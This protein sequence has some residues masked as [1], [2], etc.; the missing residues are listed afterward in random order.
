MS[1]NSNIRQK[2]GQLIM[3]D[4]RYW[5][6]DSNNQR[7]PFTKTNDIVNKIFKDYNLGGF[8]LFRENI[9]NNEQVISL[10][11]DL[12]AN[13]NT[14]IFFATDQEGG[15]VNRL[16]QGISGCGNMALAATDNPHNAYTMAKIIGDELYSLGININ[17]APAVD[18]NSNKNN[19]IIGVRSYSDNPDIVI[20]YAKNAI[21]GYHDAKI[22]DCIKH[23]PGHGDTA[24]DSHL[25]NVN[26][27][28]T[29]KELQTTEL[30][31]FSKLA[32]DCSMIM[33]AHISVPALDDTQYQSVST[34]ENIYVPATLSYKIITK[35]LKQQMKFDGLVVSDAMDMH[36]IAKHFGTIEASKL[37]ILAGIDI[38]LM[39]V[40]VWSENDL[41]KLEELFCELEKGY[42]QNSNFANA[43]DNVYTNIT[44][45][46]AKHKLDESLIFKL[47]QDEQL[48]YANQIVNSN[49][50]QQIALDIA[51]QSTT[52]VKNSGIIP[53]DL[54]KLKNIL[55]VDSDNQRLADFHSEL[56]KIVLDNNS[57]V[58]I[59]CENIN[60][61][62]IK[63]II[64]N[65]DLILLISANLRE[66]NQTYS[67]ITSIKPEQTINIAA[68]T[69]YDINY[70]DNI[71]NYVCIYGATSMDYTN[72]TKTSLKINIQTTLENIF[73]NKEIKGVLPVSL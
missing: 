66:Y 19:P 56:Q 43:V 64:E 51:K 58:I 11:R 14:P 21:N 36:A 53:C 13:T 16:Q 71:I 34:S 6:E 37:A 45:F 5:G 8:I 28:K 54:N 70:I 59:N 18:V 72:Y 57:N 33:T 47:S 10:L 55:I 15:R 69:P 41:Y 27:D 23:F 26:L 12:Q 60:N 22:I 38:L 31:P 25:G 3:M 9:Q 2:L 7:I 29:L 50:H 48:K 39:P 17:F 32:R 61:H 44:D 1:T 62:N 52:V 67:Y 4:F 42:N 49:K 68:L 65:A 20:D 24:T 46:K 73:G 40:R 30:L 35:L 63:T